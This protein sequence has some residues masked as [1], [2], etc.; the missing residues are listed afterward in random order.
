MIYAQRPKI[1]YR[2]VGIKLGISSE[3]VRQL[4]VDLTQKLR[5]HLKNR[6]ID[7]EILVSAANP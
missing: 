6:V 2:L 1:G 3:R 4:Y 5:C 7:E